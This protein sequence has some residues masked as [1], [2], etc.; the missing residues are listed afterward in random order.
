MVIFPEQLGFLKLNPSTTSKSEQNV[1]IYKSGDSAKIYQG[2]EN[3][4]VWGRQ[5]LEIEKKHRKEGWTSSMASF[6]K[7]TTASNREKK[8]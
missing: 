3:C 4:R 1:K 5:D 7:T 8:S 6:L 2:C